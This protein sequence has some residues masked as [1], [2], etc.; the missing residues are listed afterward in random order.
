MARLFNAASRKKS[1]SR[2]TNLGLENYNAA[3]REKSK[4]RC[5]NPGSENYKSLTLRTQRLG[6]QTLRDGF[7]LGLPGNVCRQA[8]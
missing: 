3:R 2:F 8:V 5:T 7:S 4:S 6:S 1:K